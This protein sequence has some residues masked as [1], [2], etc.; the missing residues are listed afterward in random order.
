MSGRNKR[1]LLSRLLISACVLVAVASTT[2]GA[3]YHF[4]YELPHQRL[5]SLD[6]L[7]SASKDEV[8]EM[9]HRVLMW[10]GASHHDAC[11]FLKEVG[12]ESSIPILRAAVPHADDSDEAIGRLA[13]CTLSH[14]QDALGTLEA[15]FGD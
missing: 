14:C 11:L 10:P 5:A 12:D 13:S 9:S 3:I 8:R 6:W 2:A 15:R 1:R 4:Y 7:E